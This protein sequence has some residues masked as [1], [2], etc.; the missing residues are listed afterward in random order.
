MEDNFLVDYLIVYIEKKSWW[1]I[2]NR[3]DNQQFIFYE[4]MTSIIK[5]NI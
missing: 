3:Y 2:H 4:K 1:K 5:I